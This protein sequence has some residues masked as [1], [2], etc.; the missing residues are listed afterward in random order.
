MAN[1]EK[2]DEESLVDLSKHF[3]ILIFQ[4]IKRNSSRK[5]SKIDQ[6]NTD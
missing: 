5:I 2:C 1:I 4:V 3:F 6:R